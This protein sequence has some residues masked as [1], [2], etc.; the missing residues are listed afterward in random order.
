MSA[1]ND[2]PHFV[3]FHPLTFLSEEAIRTVSAPAS[4][5][6][7]RGSVISSCSKPSVTRMA[8][9]FPASF[10]FF[11]SA[12]LS[13]AGFV[14]S[15]SAFMV[16]RSEDWLGGKKGR[17]RL[18]DRTNPDARPAGARAFFLASPLAVGMF[19]ARH[20]VDWTSQERGGRAE[21]RGVSDPGAHPG[22]GRR[23]A[24]RHV[25]RMGAQR[26][27][28]LPGTRRPRGIFEKSQR[29]PLCRR[30]EKSRG[31]RA[32]T[33]GGQPRRGQTHDDTRRTATAARTGALDVDFS[34]DQRRHHLCRPDRGV[35]LLDLLQL[36]GNHARPGLAFDRPHLFAFRRDAYFV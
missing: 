10:S 20:A 4:S 24:G 29:R 13:A 32:E 9:F 36:A 34:G 33:P 1:L 19:A 12:E 5:R 6:A 18:A 2:L 17:F 8:I 23:G 35:P 16:Q 28:D 7:W 11:S 27:S 21:V 26:G 3:N 14:V 22:A 15:S 25:G 31:L 30:R